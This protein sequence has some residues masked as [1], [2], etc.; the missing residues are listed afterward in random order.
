MRPATHP[1]TAPG[2]APATRPATPGATRHHPH[3]ENG[4]PS[5]SVTA[6]QWVWDKAG[7]RG[8]ARLVLLAVADKAPGPDCTARIGT[9]EMMRRVNAARS[10]T[11]AAVD[12]AL[13][14]G[15]LIE[16]EAAIGSRAALYQLPA[17]VG[18]SRVTGPDSGPLETPNGGAGTRP[19]KP[20]RAESEPPKGPESG[21]P[22]EDAETGLWSETRPPRGPES[23]PHHSP[24][25]GMSEGVVEAPAPERRTAVVP[26]FARPLVDRITASGVIVKW[27]LGDGEWF[28]LDHLI[29]RSG[30]DMLAAEA[31]KVAGRT[32][33][34]HARYF[35]KAWRD[36]PPAPAAGTAPVTPQHA[37]PNVVPFDATAPRRSR[38]QRTADMFAQILEQEAQQ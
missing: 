2:V 4:E 24:S 10:T 36:L 22:S 25:E 38:A 26:E 11:R 37:G 20:Y 6:M 27:S 29:Q 14:S 17:A 12:A 9:T 30:V 19:P 8:N 21:P 34:S 15:E 3:H 18:Y 31:V 35:L 28:G 32:S 16:I 33:V 7:A 5:L 23:G 13:E 1:L